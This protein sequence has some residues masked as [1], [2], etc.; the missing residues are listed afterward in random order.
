MFIYTESLIV[1]PHQK[2]TYI[3]LGGRRWQ[4]KILI[5][6]NENIQ[7]EVDNGEWE[8]FFFLFLKITQE[9]LS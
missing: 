4:M 3:F 2:I 1:F 9:I 6:A 5:Y 7:L 8:F